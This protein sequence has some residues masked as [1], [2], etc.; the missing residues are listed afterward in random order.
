MRKLL[1]TLFLFVA[2]VLTVAAQERVVSGRVTSADDNSG[3]PGVNV[4]IQGTTKGA[5][6]DLDGNYSVSLAEGE[7]VLVFSFVGFQ[8]QTVQVGNQT[9]IDV[10][11]QTD[12]EQLD[13]VVVI[14]YGVVRKS[15]LTGSVSSVKGEDLVKVPSSSPMQSLQGKVAGVQ[16]A[17]SSGAPGA[18]PVVRIRGTGTF[19]NSGPIYVVDGVITENIDYLNAADIER[20]EVLKDASA[21]AIYG[22][23]GANGVIMVTTRRGKKGQAAPIIN[24]SAEYSIQKLQKKI[25]LL[26][27]RQF[28]IVANEITPGSY[29]NVDAV[30]NVDWQDLL[31]ED[32]PMQNYQFSATGA[33]DKADY[34][35]GLSYFTQDGIIP[36]SDF[37]R[38]SVKIN[39]TFNLSKNIR[40]G[41]NI[42]MSPFRQQNT[43]GNAPF[44]VYRAQP[45][46]EPRKSD[47]SYSEVPGVGNVLADL[48]NTNSFR[49]GIRTVSNLFAEADLFDGL[50]FKTSIGV[51]GE[52][53][54]NKSFTPAFFVSPQ[55]QNATSDLTKGYED[56]INWQWE[57]TL[58]YVRDFDKH[59][60]NAV[61][62]YTMQEGTSEILSAGAENI[63][64]PGEDFWYLN[65]STANGALT[66][67]DVDINNNFAIISYL[68]RINYT[69]NKKYLFTATYRL[70]ASS[71][72]IRD[73]RY[74][75]FPAVAIG[76]N[77][78]NE[79][80]MES[81]PVISN[82]KLRASWG[83]IGN[84]KIAYNRIYSEVSNTTGAVFGA[85][86]TLYP[87]ASYGT[88]GNPDLRWENTHQT[89]VGL[90][91]GFFEDKLKAEI[92]WYN[93]TSK[94]ILIALPVTGY[95]GNG[96]GA[97]I[98]FNAAEVV[99]RGLEYDVSWDSEFRNIRYRIAAVGS[100]IH[101]E[102]TKVFGDEGKPLFNAGS[103]T[104]TLPGREIGAFYGY[105]VI[106]VF[107]NESELNSYPH[108]F[109]TE[110]GDLKFRDVTNDGLLNADDRTYLGSPIPTML[111]GFSFEL[112]YKG[113]NLSA[114][115]QGQTGNKI[116][117]AKETVRPDLYN[118]EKHVFDR[119]TG[120]GTSNV[121]PRSSQ[122]G[123]NF[124]PSSRFIQ[125][126][127]FFRLRNI[128]LGYNLP[129][130]FAEKVKMKSAR[131]YVRGTN[132]FT[133]TKF[134][135]YSPEIGSSDPL[136]AGIDNSTYPV[137][138]IYSA[139]INVTF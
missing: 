80:F 105:E 116:Y 119:W 84:E 17:S 38:I 35:F 10:T 52:F 44:V 103:T 139:G 21:T 23:R 99:N 126:G 135:G 54:K 62:G 115:F 4:I 75:S 24:F 122:G 72:F 124:L 95:L 43:N 70:D 47:G 37:E 109:G 104:A 53:T 27:G 1:A 34:Y 26:S 106:G 132:V 36:K 15:D 127:S 78:I 91:L 61:V 7:N 118:F 121:E 101:N 93:K 2:G 57:N 48:E 129:A 111:Y 39:N 28:A 13:E 128:T 29:N 133:S 108:L 90:E 16:I 130:S 134:T 98:T 92:G 49:R 65:P 46:I 120:E 125:D 137:T 107:Q 73:N 22:S 114:D 51:D 96:E 138:S 76:W 102:A 71:K 3:L 14:G 123:N 83:I 8:T 31:F 117:N 87:G 12:M 20:M 25:D 100:T 97:T 112:G 63:I 94:D 89:D 9:T 42:A 18:A 136:N 45:V 41:N 66:Q 50:T 19:G 82:L 79:D 55:Q 33:T 68:G 11:L 32:A 56:R 59:G 30:P 67:N 6:T 131:V 69:F 60:I 110:A 85:P 58:S 77:I 40:L 86:G 113:F 81:I 88:S 64:R 74:S 5:S